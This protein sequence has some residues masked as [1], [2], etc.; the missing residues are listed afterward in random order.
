MTNEIEPMCRCGHAQNDH[1]S[2]TVQ[3]DGEKVYSQP[4]EHCPCEVFTRK[5]GP[6]DQLIESFKPVQATA[7]DGGR[8]WA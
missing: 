3:R 4:C 6:L 7:P 2:R 5:G 1:G 8:R